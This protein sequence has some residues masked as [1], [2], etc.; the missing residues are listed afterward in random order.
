MAVRKLHKRGL[1]SSSSSLH[2]KN[3]TDPHPEYEVDFDPGMGN[4]PGFPARR[5]RNPGFTDPAWNGSVLTRRFLTWDPE[6]FENVTRTRPS[7]VIFLKYN[8]ARPG[9][10]WVNPS[11]NL[12]WLKILKQFFYSLSPIW[13]TPGWQNIKIIQVKKYFV[14][15]L[16]LFPENIALKTPG[17]RNPETYPG[18]GPEP[19]NLDFP[20][21]T[22]PGT[23]D[24]GPG[25]PGPL[26]IPVSTP[27]TRL[28]TWLNKK[29]QPGEIE[30]T[31]EK[32][33]YMDHEIFNKK[34]SINAFISDKVICST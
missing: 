14:N 21:R 10:G 1:I 16:R 24:S 28:T 6:F 30:E 17:S 4:G 25:Q 9:Q 7:P 13:L 32:L 11:E 8:P 20:T 5:F 29:P 31:S 3:E 27:E 23:R 12:V 33:T 19:V 26:P 15:N 34:P 18:P 2:L 22:Q